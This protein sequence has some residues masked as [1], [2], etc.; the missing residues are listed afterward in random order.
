MALLTTPCLA[1]RLPKSLRG[2]KTADTASNHRAHLDEL[3]AIRAAARL[4]LDLTHQTLARVTARG[5]TAHWGL[6]TTV[7]LP[8]PDRYATCIRSAS[9]IASTP[10]RRPWVA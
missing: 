5:S 8:E 9:K 3:L 4:C 10:Q 6:T 2:I 7:R 1:D